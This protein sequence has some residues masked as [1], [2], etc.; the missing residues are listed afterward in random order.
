VDGLTSEQL[1]RFHRK[2]RITMI[3]R[4]NGILRT[5]RV[6]TEALLAS[7]VGCGHATAVSIVNLAL[8]QAH[9]SIRRY[10]TPD[11]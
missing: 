7:E 2:H 11:E 8:S 10:L 1:A 6:R 4:L 5:L 3:R 9:L